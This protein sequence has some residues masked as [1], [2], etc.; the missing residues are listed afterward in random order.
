MEDRVTH[1]H[2]SSHRTRPSIFFPLLLVA[3]GVILLLHTV[4]VLPG[5]AWS[6][7]LR[8]WPVLFITSA[9]DSIYRGDGYVGAVIWGGLG[10]FL[11]LSNLGMLPNF[12]WTMLLRWWP[13]LLIAIGLDLIIGR[14]SIWSAVL[15]L[16]L[17]LVIIAGI[18]WL[19]L[20][21]TPAAPVQSQDMQ[22]Q[23]Q[24][25]NSLDA[26]IS[27]AAGEVRISGGAESGNA[28]EA[29]ITLSGNEELSESYVVRDGKGFFDLDNKGLF[30][31]Y[32]AFQAPSDRTV[33]ELYFNEDVPLRLKSHLIAGEQHVDLKQLDI[34]SFDIKTIFGK[35]T[36][37]LPMEGSFDGNAEVIFGELEVSMPENADVCI[38][39]DTALTGIH[40]PDGF[41]RQDDLILSPGASQAGGCMQVDVNLP[42]GSLR[43]TTH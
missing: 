8:W 22:W 16:V 5:S 42:I 15:G 27:A 9:L 29:A 37:L 20:G 25:A 30:V 1:K 12:S 13:V 11:L 14:H 18:V 2:S 39:A 34:S 19:S 4:N 17:G 21:M 28:L 7:I 38:Y 43:V 35:T 32:P 36:L 10:V 33:W 31:I 40:L 6:T 3:V 23:L 26:S 24:G 41:T